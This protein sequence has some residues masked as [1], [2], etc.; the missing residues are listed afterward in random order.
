M[1]GSPTIHSFQLERSRLCHMEST[2]QP[3]VAV[4]VVVRRKC[5]ARGQEG[6]ARSI[7]V[8]HCSKLQHKCQLC[9]VLVHSRLPS[10]QQQ[11]PM[12]GAPLSSI[13]AFGRLLKLPHQQR[14]SAIGRLHL[15]TGCL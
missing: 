10:R 9:T 11:K 2:L 6:K 13:L 8:S 1:Q 14:N 4:V 7:P 5:E 3:A 15:H 12:A